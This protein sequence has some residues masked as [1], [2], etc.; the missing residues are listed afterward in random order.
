MR[1]GK[2]HRDGVLQR[3][4]APIGKTA[5]QSEADVSRFIEQYHDREIYLVREDGGLRTDARCPRWRR[6]GR[7]A[8]DR[9]VYTLQLRTG[10]D[11][12]LVEAFMRVLDRGDL[13]RE[14]EDEVGFAPLLGLNPA[15]MS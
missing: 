9:L 6:G 10:F 15:T 8:E 5:E 11:P 7:V 3:I 14:E 2:L 1:G 13:H 4:A 12:Q